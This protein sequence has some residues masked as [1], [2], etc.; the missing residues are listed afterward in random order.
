MWYELKRLL[1]GC[2]IVLLIL[3]LLI[4]IWVLSVVPY[5]SP[6]GHWC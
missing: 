4:S 5:V 1:T 6:C 2:A 3:S